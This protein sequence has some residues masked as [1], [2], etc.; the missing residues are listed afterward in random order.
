MTVARSVFHKFFKVQDR[1]DVAVTGAGWAAF[2][3]FFDP[4]VFRETRLVESG[5]MSCA[6]RD[7]EGVAVRMQKIADTRLKRVFSL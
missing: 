7:V 3:T 6:C 2:K 1:L 4:G 5:V